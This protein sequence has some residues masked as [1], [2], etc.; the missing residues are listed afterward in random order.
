LRIKRTPLSSG[1]KVGR[2]TVVEFVRR[3]TTGKTL[4]LCVCECGT[5]KE[6]DGAS[7]RRGGSLS[8]GC[9][10]RDLAKERSTTHDGSR[11]KMYRTWG[12]MLT[13]C[14]HPKSKDWPK[15]GG[16]GI[17]V[18]DR[19]R[20]SFADFY[21]DMGDKPPDHQ[22]DRI[23]NDGPYSPENCRWVTAKQN[24][25]NRRDSIFLTLNGETLHINEWAERLGVRCGALRSRLDDGWSIERTLTEPLAP[26]RTQ[27]KPS[28]EL[29]AQ[30]GP[31]GNAQVVDF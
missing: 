23:N 24:S 22:L 10:A 21:D 13:R 17:V 12:S 26:R 18:C 20:K 14:C 9:L 27:K 31:K 4:W 11:T 16:R 25:R 3:F 1:L 8:C 29:A 2:W 6:V 30:N 5:S 28:K 15:Y 7:L 19:W